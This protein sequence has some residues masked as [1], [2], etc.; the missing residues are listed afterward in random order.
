MNSIILGAV[1]VILL[2]LLGVLV[3]FIRELMEPLRFF[4]Q[5]TGNIQILMD[6]YLQHLE[7][8]YSMDVFYGDETLKS[9]IEHTRLLSEEVGKYKELFIFEPGE[10]EE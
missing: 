3:W 5:N 10:E 9:L 4:Q 2:I 7:G 8:V 1:C 6:E